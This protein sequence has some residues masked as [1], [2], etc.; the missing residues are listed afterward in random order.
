MFRND[1]CKVSRPAKE[2]VNGEVVYLTP[3]VVY[4]NI[5]CNLSK[6]K[7]TP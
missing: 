6:N 5:M 2:K 7:L 4:D 1:I 3:S